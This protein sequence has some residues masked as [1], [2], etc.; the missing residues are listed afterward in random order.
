MFKTQ[1]REANMSA[2]SL[3][4][5]LGG[6]VVGCGGGVSGI[7]DRDYPAVS[8]SGPEAL[9]VRQGVEVTRVPLPAELVEVNICP[10]P[11]KKYLMRVM[12]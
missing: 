11:L 7:H 4:D 2:A 9:A 10:P 3:A 8:G 1:A 5:E 6:G 12:S